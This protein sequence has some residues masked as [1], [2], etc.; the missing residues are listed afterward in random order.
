MPQLYQ[1]PDFH[2]YCKNIFLCLQLELYLLP[3]FTQKAHQRKAY[4]I[5]SVWGVVYKSNHLYHTLGKGVL[6]ITV[7]VL[8]NNKIPDL[9]SQLK[10][11]VSFSEKAI[12]SRRKSTKPVYVIL[13]L[14]KKQR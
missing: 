12:M 11:K 7:F 9:E 10:C 8:S 2:L 1:Q 13:A 4:G 14:Y 3:Q 5:G 6:A